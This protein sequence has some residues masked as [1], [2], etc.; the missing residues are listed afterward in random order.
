MGERLGAY[1]ADRRDKGIG[2]RNKRFADT[3]GVSLRLD[4]CKVGLE[5]GVCSFGAEQ[6]E[7]FER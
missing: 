2:R 5:F 1:E 3:K 4:G 7:N 6:A